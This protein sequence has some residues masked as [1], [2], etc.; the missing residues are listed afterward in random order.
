MD[1]GRVSFMSFER[2]ELP[3]VMDERSLFRPSMMLL[4]MRQ[5]SRRGNLHQIQSEMER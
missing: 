5:T 4:M 1:R 3:W 2:M